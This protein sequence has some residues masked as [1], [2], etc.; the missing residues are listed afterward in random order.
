MVQCKAMKT[1]TFFSVLVVQFNS[2]I[3]AKNVKVIIEFFLQSD[4]IYMQILYTNLV[5][6]WAG[7]KKLFFSVLDE[8][9]NTWY[10]FKHRLKYLVIKVTNHYWLKNVILIVLLSQLLSYYYFFKFLRWYTFYR[11][12]WHSDTQPIFDSK[13]VYR[14]TETASKSQLFAFKEN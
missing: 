2:Q 5:G 12:E 11:K 8:F 3:I 7:D 9:F 1:K 10:S 14:E 13:D 6:E 4:I